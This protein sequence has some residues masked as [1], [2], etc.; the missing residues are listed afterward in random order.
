MFL[1]GREKQFQYT[2]I[3]SVMNCLNVSMT[4]QR[5]YDALCKMLEPWLY[6]SMSG[7]SYNYSFMQNRI[8]GLEILANTAHCAIS[9]FMCKDYSHH[10]HMKIVRAFHAHESNVIFLLLLDITWFHGMYWP[11]TW[12]HVQNS[13]EFHKRHNCLW[14][15]CTRQRIL[16]VN[17]SLVQVSS[18]MKKYTYNMYRY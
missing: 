4:S 5:Y 6:H 2:I 10:F 11:F 1:I 3:I 15:T 14:Y 12:F 9:K 13:R 18:G 16:L 8:R 7:I 17:W